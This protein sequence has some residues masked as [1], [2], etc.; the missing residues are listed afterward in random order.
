M[1]NLQTITVR[2]EPNS[3]KMEIVYIHLDGLQTIGLLGSAIYSVYKDT[4][5]SE[6]RPILTNCKSK[7]CIQL[8][9]DNLS[10]A[11]G[12][13]MENGENIA[14]PVIAKGLLISALYGLCCKLE[15]SNF[16]PMKAMFEGIEI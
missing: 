4:F 15:D 3:G 8:V 5:Q 9:G 7:V 16:D 14:D 2:H 10:M 12:T 13:E 11:F 6:P 1:D